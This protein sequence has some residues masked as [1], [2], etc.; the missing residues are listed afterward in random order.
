MVVSVIIPTYNR[1]RLI[2][3]TLE[4]FVRQNLPAGDFEIIVS[5]NN[6]T[7]ETKKVIHDFIAA[8]PTHSIR[9][10]F[11]VRQGVHYARNSAAKLANGDY[12]YFTDD[13]MIA[14]PD[15]LKELLNIFHKDKKI[16]SA[17]GRV[18]PK[19]EVNPPDWILKLCNNALLS[20]NDPDYPELISE[21][22]CNVFSCHQMILRNAFFGSGGFNPENTKG[23]WI[24][25]GETGLNLK[26]KK[27]GYKFA[28]TG[29]SVIHH[30]I[31]AGR[32]TQAYL[33]KRM[34]NQGNGDIYTRYRTS[35]PGMAGLF[36]HLLITLVKLAYS[37]IRFIFSFLTG[38]IRWRLNLAVC[39]YYMAEVKYIAKLMTNAGHRALV[40]KDNWLD[41]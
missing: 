35:R 20:L 15:L 23:E 36:L 29:K 9:Y 11:E 30:I 28:F 13:D 5:D 27:L 12:L 17:T 31:P 4:S 2:G 34:K 38:N 14:E 32:L 37:P 39:Y 16:G 26:I 7:D 24:G 6:S 33:N 40:L 10:F 18:L 19:F 21:E 22:D 8:H 25:D 1:S 3:L 41:D